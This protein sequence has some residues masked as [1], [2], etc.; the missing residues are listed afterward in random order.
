ME[1]IRSVEELTNT[2]IETIVYAFIYTINETPEDTHFLF[3]EEE[4]KRDKD[5]EMVLQTIKVEGDESLLE[6]M[7]KKFE[8]PINTTYDEF[9]KSIGILN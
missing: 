9:K 6:K 7:I 2:P 8:F 5:Y 3:Y 1:V 4:E